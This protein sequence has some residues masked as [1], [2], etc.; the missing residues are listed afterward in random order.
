MGKS[1]FRAGDQSPG[2][3]TPDPRL[4]VIGPQPWMSLSTFGLPTVRL[5]PVS[6]ERYH[7]PG[8]E[9]APDYGAFI[10][11]LLTWEQLGRRLQANAPLQDWPPDYGT[12]IEALLTWEQLTHRLQEDVQ[13]AIAASNEELKPLRDPLWLNL[14]EHRWLS[15]DREESYSDWLAWILQGMSGAKEIL[16]LFAL[17]DDG[18][19]HMSE[20]FSVQRELASESG[21]TDVVVRFGDRGLFIIEVKVGP[22][23]KDLPDQLKRYEEW[24]CNQGAGQKLFALLGTVKPAHEITPFVFTDWLTLCRRLRR[25]AKAVKGSDLLRAA[26]I[27]IFCGAV[28][29]NVAELSVRGGHFHAMATVNHLRRWRHEV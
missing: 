13:A 18:A 19:R 16:P 8:M 2:S 12:L 5:R 17:G 20:K 4:G 3:L 25:Y 26:A 14:G 24:A 1:G 21:R 10:E 28:E 11:A 15:K 29:E 27:L 23:G 22:T 7:L 9:A 6:G